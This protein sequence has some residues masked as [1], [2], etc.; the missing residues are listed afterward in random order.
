M[1]TPEKNEI[2]YSLEFM[3]DFIHQT[4]EVYPKPVYESLVVPLAG[5]LFLRWADDF[6]TL[7]EAEAESEKTIYQTTIPSDLRWRSWRTL[8]GTRLINFIKNDLVP[9]LEN[10]C[11]GPISPFVRRVSLGFELLADQPKDICNWLMQK[12][13]TV[14]RYGIIELMYMLDY[15]EKNRLARVGYIPLEISS[16]ISDLACPKRGESIYYPC[17]GTGSLFLHL[18]ASIEKEAG[19][20]ALPANT[21]TG[22]EIDP[23]NHVVAI[24]RLAYLNFLNSPE[25]FNLQWEDALDRTTVG[26]T[27]DCIVA[28]PPWG[29]RSENFFGDKISAM[30]QNRFQVNSTHIESLF[31]QH[32]MDSLSPGGR[33]VV[34]LPD[35]ALSRLGAD[36]K[37]REKLLRQYRVEGVL[38]LSPKMINPITH[39]KSSLLVFRRD[40]PSTSIRFYDFKDEINL[41]KGDPRSSSYLAHEFREGKPSG[42]LWETSINK[43]ENRAWELLAKPFDDEKLD[44]LITALQN[45][46]RD[47]A[48]ATL[49]NISS[50]SAGLS[51]VQNGITTQS[52]DHIERVALITPSD[53]DYRGVFSP[54]VFLPENATKRLQENH[55]L[56]PGDILLSTSGEVGKTAVVPK[57]LEKSVVSK[58]FAVIRPSKKVSSEY[59]AAILQSESVQMWLKGYAQG[60]TIRRLPMKQLEKLQVPV[61]SLSNQKLL[62]STWS[63][64]K[65]DA[66]LL[67]LDKL[68]GKDIDPTVEWLNTAAAFQDLRIEDTHVGTANLMVILDRVASEISEFGVKQVRGIVSWSKSEKLMEWLGDLNQA[69]RLLLGIAQVPRGMGRIVLLD[70]VYRVFEPVHS[71]LEMDACDD[72]EEELRELFRTITRP[73]MNLIDAE[74]EDVLSEISLKP[75]LEPSWILVGKES[76]AVFSIRNNSLV[77]LRNIS[78]T[79]VPGL[80]SNQKA[81][82]SERGKIDVPLKINAQPKPGTFQFKAHWRAE[83]IDGKSISGEIPLAVQVRSDLDSGIAKELGASPY[84]VGSPIDRKE[85]FFGRDKIIDRI[86][87]QL[88]P[89]HRANI[90]LL[91]GNRRTG[92][93]SILKRLQSEGVLP[94]WVVVDCSFQGAT[95]DDSRVGLPTR[96]VFRLMAKQIGYA[97]Y[98]TGMPVWLPDQAP[99]DPGRPFKTQLVTALSS[100]FSGETAFETF[101]IYLQ[102]VLNRIRPRRLMLMLDEFDKLQE[103]I[104]AGITSPQVPENIRYLLHTYSDLSAILTGSRRL[105]RLREEYWSALFGFGYRIEVGALPLKDAQE[106]V[107][108]PVKDHLV[109]VPQARD[110]VVELCACH[111]FLIQSLCNRIFEYAVRTNEKTITLNA[112]KTAAEEMVHDNEHFRTLWDYAGTERRRLVLAIFTQLLDHP[113]PITINFLE[114]KFEELGVII[115]AREQL[116]NDIEFLR[117]LELIKMDKTIKESV[118][119][120]A[121]P[122]MGDWIQRHIDFESSRLSAVREGQEK[123]I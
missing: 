102:E 97:L 91:E 42:Q 82:L 50:I 3:K 99:P 95:G 122:L 37:I 8:R 76:E 11:E 65:G 69:T 44:H 54:S 52:E 39:I 107:T 48:V 24:A 72:S 104:D 101:E 23:L 34:A 46:D 85:M 16:L 121:I 1:T 117:E 98:A 109:F 32:I 86:Q 87:R 47:L 6:E 55:Y 5:L 59:L 30:V 123:D 53:I 118:Y 27:F 26:E 20:A 84:I 119:Q 18:G 57:S 116:G 63:E 10:A 12:T 79:T 58:N 89:D 113:M 110:R 66:L 38:S 94:E 7:R 62:A 108:R 114:T 70:R 33:A 73:I 64:R 51:Y 22:I 61:P 2:P 25:A 88:S 81:Y 4:W 28:V 17:F 100:A 67:L 78:V 93:T 103:G 68:T 19:N 40:K 35:V 56:K 92:K 105:K 14:P 115:P 71:E 90:I 36:T 45:A 75:K 49:G 9:V 120:L 77:P 60:G 31:L 80:G 96:E 41:E 43:L 21:I 13:D 106:L 112:V 83:R 15:I 74:I 111:P 29:K